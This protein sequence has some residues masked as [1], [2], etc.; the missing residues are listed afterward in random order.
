MAW[1]LHGGSCCSRKAIAY[2]KH[3]WRH[4]TRLWGHWNSPSW[5]LFN[6][7]MKKQN[8][9]VFERKLSTFK[10]NRSRSRDRFRELE[11][12]YDFNCRFAFLASWLRSTWRVTELQRRSISVLESVANCFGLNWRGKTLGIKAVFAGFESERY[13]WWVE[14][15]FV[16]NLHTMTCCTVNPRKLQLYF[17]LLH[18]RFSLGLL[19]LLYSAFCWSVLSNRLSYNSECNFPLHGLYMYQAS[20]GTPF[21]DEVQR[22]W[23]VPILNYKN[24]VKSNRLWKCTTKNSF[25]LFLLVGKGK[26][27]QAVPLNSRTYCRFAIFPLNTTAAIHGLCCQ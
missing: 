23:R 16:W 22:L 7:C 6:A 13:V 20:W 27:W 4:A 8:C 19:L 12:C 18:S 14:I 9:L 17:A 21:W 26:N 24:L 15:C 1:P 11:K 5:R 2:L 10:E 25:R 3:A